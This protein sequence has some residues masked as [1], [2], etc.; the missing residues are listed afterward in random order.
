[1]SES[2]SLDV[3]EVD[4][5]REMDREEKE[6]EEGIRTDIRKLISVIPPPSLLFSRQ[7]ST[8]KEKRL[9]LRYDPSVGE[10]EI[11]VSSALAREIGIKDYVEVTVA[12]KKRFRLKAI[13]ADELDASYV[14]VNPDQMRHLGISDNSICTVRPT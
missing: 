7:R 11:K 9:R 8:V 5:N 2:P 3:D 12:G 1:M 6:V 4:R 13:V 14:N 10:G